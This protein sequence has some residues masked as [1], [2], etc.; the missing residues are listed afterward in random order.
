MESMSDF[1]KDEK[2]WHIRRRDRNIFFQKVE[3]YDDNDDLR[4]SEYDK[5]NLIGFQCMRSL[6]RIVQSL[7]MDH[8]LLENRVCFSKEIWRLSIYEYDP[9]TFPILNVPIKCNVISTSI[10]ILRDNGMQNSS[11]ESLAKVLAVLEYLRK[12]L[13]AACS[14]VVVN[15]G[16]PGSSKLKDESESMNSETF[17]KSEASRLRRW[18]IGSASS[19]GSSRKSF[20]NENKGTTGVANLHKKDQSMR[21]ENLNKFHEYKPLIVSLYHKLTNLDKTDHKNDVI[22]EFVFQCVCKFI[23]A[24]CK[25]LLADYVERKILHM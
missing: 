15:N 22:F 3:I 21:K 25:L 13:D 18:S 9:S 7:Q 16:N 24:D 10:D 4:I 19:K 23:I 12:L 17:S 2:K 6:H 8:V 20:L 1:T 5:E 14:N 11:E